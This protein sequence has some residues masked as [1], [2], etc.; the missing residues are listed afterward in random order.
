MF[1]ASHSD[2]EIS[3]FLSASRSDK[4]LNEAGEA[5]F[6]CQYVLDLAKNRSQMGT[7]TFVL[8]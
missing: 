7:C 8:V 1:T 6:D 4:P 3:L 2:R 5:V